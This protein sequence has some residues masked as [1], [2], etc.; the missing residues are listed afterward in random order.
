LKVSTSRLV[1]LGRAYDVLDSIT[2]RLAPIAEVQWT[3]PVGAVRRGEDLAGDV[4]LVV[5]TK[6]PDLVF[7]ALAS[8]AD[9]RVSPSE[10]TSRVILEIDRIE[11]GV[12]CITPDVAGGALLHTTGNPAH[13]AALRARASSRGGSLEPWGLR[14]AAGVSIASSED[15]IYTELGLPFIPPELR[16]GT[17]EIAAAEQGRLPTLVSTADIRGDLHM[18]SFWS[19]GRDSIEAMVVAAVALGYE[20]IAITDHSPTS[21]AS[22]SLTTDGVSRQADE[23]AS[24][25]ETYPQIAILHGCEADIL[26]D[27]S[28]DFPDRVLEQFDI[29]LASLHESLGHSPATLLRRYELAMRH[30]LVALITHPTNRVVPHRAGYE[31]DYDRLFQL[32]IET[33][34][35]L[36]I[37]G[38]PSHLD[39]DASLARRA[40]QAGV[41]LTID[42]DCHRSSQLGRQMQLGVV[43]AR[44]GWVEAAHVLNTRPLA[45]VRARIT[46]KRAGRA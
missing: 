44:R 21:A 31:L 41:T 35:L 30:P 42:S 18:H 24:L 45:D 1:P 43:T 27:G 37:D 38:G 26:E 14:T 2:T 8:L 19:D 16:S 20:Y 15:A 4:E 32:A 11:T 34:T 5:G 17:D 28:L 6:A 10:D 39:L 13:L 12:R 46:A 40:V 7:D 29:V 25:R 33:G 36:E 9:A 23:I 3:T 22:R